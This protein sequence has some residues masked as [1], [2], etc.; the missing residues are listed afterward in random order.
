MLAQSSIGILHHIA[1]LGI[2]VQVNASEKSHSSHAAVQNGLRRFVIPSTVTSLIVWIALSCLQ[3]SYT[4]QRC[5]ESPLCWALAISWGLNMVLAYVSLSAT[6]AKCHWP[7][8]W[9]AMNSLTSTMMIYCSVRLLQNLVNHQPAKCTNSQ[10]ESVE[11]PLAP[12]TPS[13]SCQSILEPPPPYS[14]L[15]DGPITNDDIVK[16]ELGKL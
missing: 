8:L 7:G 16:A 13:S 12:V 3:G 2:I 6:Y 15:H 9:L 14:Q 11:I 5:H 10:G 4:A 1:T